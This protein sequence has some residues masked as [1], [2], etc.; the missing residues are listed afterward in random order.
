MS[1]DLLPAPP[2]SGQVVRFRNLESDDEDWDMCVLLLIVVLLLVIVIWCASWRL[3][4]GVRAAER[5][6]NICC[7]CPDLLALQILLIWLGFELTILP[8]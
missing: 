4:A 8:L 3:V 7:C 5:F 6:Q 1:P 2:E